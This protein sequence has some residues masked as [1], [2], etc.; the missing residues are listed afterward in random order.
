MTEETKAL[1]T[2]G[3]LSDVLGRKVHIKTDR[4]GMIEYFEAVGEEY[5]SELSIYELKDKLE[6]WLC[7]QGYITAVWDSCEWLISIDDGITSYSRLP[8]QKRPPNDRNHPGGK[9]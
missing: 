8:R 1:I 7:G 2:E 9:R 4:N 5:E 6:E 3:M